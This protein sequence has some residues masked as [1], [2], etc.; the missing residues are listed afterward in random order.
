MKLG[1]AGERREKGTMND[2]EWIKLG[3]RGERRE[4][5]Q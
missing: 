5:E 2:D 1:V 4:K 3:I